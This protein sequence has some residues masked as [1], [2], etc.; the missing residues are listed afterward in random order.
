MN[1]LFNL[2]ESAGDEGLMVSGLIQSLG[3]GDLSLFGKG[4]ELAKGPSDPCEPKPSIDTPFSERNSSK[5][6]Y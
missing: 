5:S 1:D 2:L 6:T 4:C 3:L